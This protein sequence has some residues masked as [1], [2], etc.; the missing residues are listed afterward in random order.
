MSL[1]KV[2]EEIMTLMALIAQK[3]RDEA[4]IKIEQVFEIIH[5]G[6]DFST[7]DEELVY[8]GKYLK[9]VEGLQHKLQEDE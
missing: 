8:W 7:N 3:R 2:Q 5:E 9:I 4:E 1:A 6:L